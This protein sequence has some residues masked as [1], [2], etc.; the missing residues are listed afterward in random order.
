MG[1]ART[2]TIKSKH[3]AAKSGIKSSKEASRK[4]PVDGVTQDRKAKGTAPKHVRRLT[5]AELKA[6]AFKK[7]TFTAKELGIPELNKITPVGV[8]KPKGQKKGKVFVDDRVREWWWWWW[9]RRST[10]ADHVSQESM[11]TI[12]AIVQAEKE[13]QIESKMIKARAMEEI[14]EARRAEAERKEAERKEKFEETKDLLRRKRKR[15]SERG[16]EDADDL[17]SKRDVV[18]GTQARRPKRK[19]AFA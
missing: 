5:P 17:G 2:R 13:G 14:R 15:G 12:L 16:G 19:V 9:W 11:S 7:R 4:A 8:T 1:V 10:R 3:A 18:T 6:K